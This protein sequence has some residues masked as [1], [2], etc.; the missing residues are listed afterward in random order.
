MFDTKASGGTANRRKRP[1]L[2][3]E[4]EAAL[5]KLT[6]T[7]W[8]IEVGKFNR[9]EIYQERLDELDAR[10]ARHRQQQPKQS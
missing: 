9:D 10:R 7:S 5:E 1:M 2:T 8:P 3:A 4:P 6:S